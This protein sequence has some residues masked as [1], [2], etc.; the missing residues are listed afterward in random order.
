MA[1]SRPL[2]VDIIEK[3]S[4]CLDVDGSFS[5][6]TQVL[7]ADG[8]GEDGAVQD[9]GEDLLRLGGFHDPLGYERVHGE[10]HRLQALR[11]SSGVLLA[12]SLAS[13]LV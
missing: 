5:T 7:W 6:P 3:F 11:G 2:Y 9:V 10:A 8:R 13:D 4:F 1:L 12:A